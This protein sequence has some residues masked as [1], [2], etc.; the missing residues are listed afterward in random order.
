MKYHTQDFFQAH[1]LGFL[2]HVMKIKA[3]PAHK[4]S[5]YLTI[6]TCLHLYTQRHIYAGYMAILA[7]H[8]EGEQK[9]MSSFIFSFAFLFHFLVTIPFFSIFLSVSPVITVLQGT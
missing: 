2:S 4:F 1:I 7:V 6:C 5:E 3:L 8:E 9:V